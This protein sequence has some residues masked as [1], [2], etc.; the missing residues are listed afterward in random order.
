MKN[1]ITII[2]LL[3]AHDCLILGVIGQTDKYLDSYLWV[4]LFPGLM[5]LA[6]AIAINFGKEDK[7]MKSFRLLK[8]NYK[9]KIINSLHYWTGKKV[10]WNK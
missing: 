2:L 10:I 8:I 1:F 5:L 3:I 7:K 6:T 4:L 9:K